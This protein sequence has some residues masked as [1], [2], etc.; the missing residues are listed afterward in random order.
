MAHAL[1]DGDMLIVLRG[2]GTAH[3]AMIRV[4]ND[5]KALGLERA[6]RVRVKKDVLQVGRVLPSLDGDRTVWKLVLDEKEF[7][8]NHVDRSLM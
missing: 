4:Q 5:L 8:L 7:P 6:Y 2:E 1:I 3:D